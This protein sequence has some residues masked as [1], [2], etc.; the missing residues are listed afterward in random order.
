[1]IQIIFIP[2]FIYW[3]NF[4]HFHVIRKYIS[5]WK[6]LKTSVRD[7]ALLGMPKIRV[8]L[9]FTSFLIIFITCK[10]G[11]GLNLNSTVAV[12]TWAVGDWSSIGCILWASLSPI[13]TKCSLHSSVICFLSVKSLPSKL[14][15]S[16]SMAL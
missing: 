16:I 3:S 12:L 13:E 5:F 1:M 14:I 10:T 7:G 6:K 9:L 8:A 2:R 15:F 4:T 11:T